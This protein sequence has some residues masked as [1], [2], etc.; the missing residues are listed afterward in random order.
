VGDDGNVTDI[1]ALRHGFHCTTD[2]V[3]NQRSGGA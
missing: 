3:A 1:G 2:A